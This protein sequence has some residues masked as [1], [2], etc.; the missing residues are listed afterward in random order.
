MADELWQ[1][2][3]VR[4]DGLHHGMVLKQ[5]EHEADTGTGTG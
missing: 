2:E 4:L 3:C 5:V 1:A